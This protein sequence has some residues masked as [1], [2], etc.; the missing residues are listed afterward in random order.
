MDR[1]DR[2]DRVK[3]WIEKIIYTFVTVILLCAVI[4]TMIVHVYNFSEEEAYEKLHLE[5]SQIKRDI[6]LQMLSD[7]ENLI[8]MARLAAK[9]H[10]NGEEYDLLFE[11]FK[12]I[13]LFENIGILLPD[14][15]L[16]TRIG[17]VVAAGEIDFESEVLKGERVSGRVNDLTVSG[18]QV[19]RSAVPVKDKAGNTIA[20]LYGIIEVDSL[21]KHY[22]DDAKAAGADLFV[23]EAGNGNLIIDTMNEK[24]GNITEYVSAV[25]GKGYSYDKLVSDLTYGQSGFSSFLSKKNNE[26][27]YAHYAPLA[28]ADWQIMLTKP[29]SVVFAGARATGI[30]LTLMATAIIFIMIVYV[31]FMFWSERKKQKVSSYA[32]KIRKNLL[33]INQQK[34]KLDDALKDICEFSKARAA[35]IVDN[36]GPDYNYMIPSECKSALTDEERKYFVKMILKYEAKHHNRIGANVLVLQMD[37]KKLKDEMPE[38]CEFVLSK[39]IYKIAFASVSSNNSVANVIGVL[40]SK[41]NRIVDLLKDI[42]IC[43]SMSVYNKNYLTQTETL[44]LTDSLTGMAN[45]MAY[46]QDIKL[47][48]MQNIGNYTCV[49]IDVNEL[50]YYNDKNGH[51]AGDQMLIFVT[52]AFKKEF[53]DSKIYRMGGDEF[54]IFVFDMSM[55]EVEKRAKNANERIE[56]MKYHVSIGITYNEG[57]TSIEKLVSEAEKLMYDQKAKYYQSK[58]LKRLENLPGHKMETVLTGIKEIDT[59]LAVMSIRYLGVYCVRHSTDSAYQVLATAY[60]AQ[61]LKE[62]EGFM[63][64]IHK[65]I[66]DMVK[67]EYHRAMRGL[68]DYDMIEKQLEAESVIKISYTRFDG[69]R[70]ILNI[71]S[72]EEKDIDTVWIFEKDN[73][74]E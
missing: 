45:R 65:Y 28:I 31:T 15:T 3:R 56:S 40:N 11:S 27:L 38:F 70:I 13:G 58:E 36:Y 26:Y 14:N 66:H 20:I 68:L 8:T 48:S 57:K 17:R 46:K 34:D 7:R 71:Y 25:Y 19:V 47:M 53:P 55:D 42:A 23:I 32:S 52:Q 60:F 61:M 64:S 74:E 1:V 62:S 44:A 29:E 63:S 54:L 41:N 73:A 30:Y 50:H 37:F 12:A 21:K 18:K 22:I 6:N 51:A 72:A 33:L 43:F 2:K 16:I 49:Y 10:E 5:T 59:C 35:F 4:L 67:P 39:G 69:E 24:P 9:L